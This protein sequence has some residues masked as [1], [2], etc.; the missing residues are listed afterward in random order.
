MQK[1]RTS[2]KEVNRKQACTYCDGEG[3]TNIGFE[4]EQRKRKG[5]ET[6]GK[7]TLK[8]VGRRGE[9]SSLE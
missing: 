9:D 7:R 5:E 4:K 6:L 8:G 2:Y 1:D 3:I